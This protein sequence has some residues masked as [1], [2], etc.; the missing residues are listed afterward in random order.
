MEQSHDWAIGL[1]GV[2]TGREQQVAAL[3]KSG[4]SNKGIA[5]GLGLSEGTVNTST[6]FLEARNQKPFS[7]P[8]DLIGKAA[9]RRPSEIFTKTSNSEPNRRPEIVS[10]SHKGK[11][12]PISILRMSHSGRC[13]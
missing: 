4:L 6:N 1:I 10:L 7:T 8:A 9:L 5:K 2:L 11:R 12:S 13:R 3:A